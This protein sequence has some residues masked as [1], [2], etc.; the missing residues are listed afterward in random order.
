VV[1]FANQTKA[2]TA[3]EAGKVQFSVVGDTAV[4]R[5]GDQEIQA[6]LSFSPNLPEGR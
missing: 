1:T 4:C 5:I 6:N 2:Q 3:R